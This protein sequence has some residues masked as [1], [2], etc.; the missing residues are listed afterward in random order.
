MWDSRPADRAYLGDPLKGSRHNRGCAV[1][2]TLFDLKTGMEVAMPSAYDDFTERAHPT[3]DGGDASA[4]TNRDLLRQVME[5]EGFSVYETE[6]WHFD[7]KDW[8]SYPILNTP[9][10]AQ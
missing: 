8:A 10:A 6:W 1:D 9:L 7:F 5:A 4:R 3:Y 2:L